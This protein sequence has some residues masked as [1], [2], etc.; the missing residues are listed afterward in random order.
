MKLYFKL[1]LIQVIPAKY[2]AA[3]KEL[4]A[5]TILSVEMLNKEEKCSHFD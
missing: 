4:S 3:T 1:F 2:K 5:A